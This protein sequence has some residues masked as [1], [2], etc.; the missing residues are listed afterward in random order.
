MEKGRRGRCR[1]L[2]LDQGDM[3]AGREGSSRAREAE[4]GMSLLL[5]EGVYGRPIR[6][7]KVR[8]GI[9]KRVV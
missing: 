5:E 1:F 6:D 9:L 3:L 7:Q 8:I 4:R 2:V